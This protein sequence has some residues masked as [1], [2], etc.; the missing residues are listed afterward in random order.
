MLLFIPQTYLHISLTVPTGIS[1]YQDIQETWQ[2]DIGTAVLR[3]TG[4]ATYQWHQVSA[5]VDIQGRSGGLSSPNNV[6][7]LVRIAALS[8]LLGQSTPNLPYTCAIIR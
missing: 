2:T 1:Q 4:V 7:V 6:L 3:I 8:N 5:L